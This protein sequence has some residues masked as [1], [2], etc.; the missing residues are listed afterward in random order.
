MRRLIT[1]SVVALLAWAG[2]ARAVEVPEGKAAVVEAVVGQAE[3]LTLK[4]SQPLHVADVLNFGDRVATGE[5]GRIFLRQAGQAVTR[6]A[7]NTELTLDDPGQRKGTFLILAKGFIRFL[8]SH[9]REGESFE[10]RANNAVAAVKGTDAGVEIIG[11]TVQS[12]VYSSDHKDALVVTDGSGQQHDL[13]PGQTGILGPDGFNQHDLNDQDRQHGDDTFHGLPAADLGQ[14]DA[15][16][17]PGHAD[18]D[19]YIQDALTELGHDLKL[20]GNKESQDRNNDLAAGRM[21]VDRFG[22]QVQIANNLY[23]SAPDTVVLSTTTSRLSG[24]VTSAIQTTQWNAALPNDAW[25]K[26]ISLALNDP[27]NLS[28]VP[29]LPSLSSNYPPLWYRLNSHLTIADPV[30]DQ[31]VLTTLYGI[32]YFASTNFVQDYIQD[33]WGYNAVGGSVQLY[34]DLHSA[35]FASATGVLATDA[36]LLS[37][38]GGTVGDSSSYYNSIAPS[39]AGATLYNYFYSTGQALYQSFYVLDAKGG[40][41]AL[42]P[43]VAAGAARTNGGT[44]PNPIDATSFLGMDRSVNLEIEFNLPGFFAQ[45]IDLMAMP[46]LFDGMGGILPIFQA[47]S[48]TG[49]PCNGNCG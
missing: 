26:V 38:F 46:A 25:L 39:G 17:V 47:P 8:V 23:R 29:V 2:A 37:N 44:T 30:G 15:G 6:L 48:S 4:G 42:P 33:L 10:V 34:Y 14:G 5:N 41:L 49:V 11:D 18:L 36:P 19:L 1:V 21:A 13:D 45:P 43:A 3:L 35:W 22:V 12:T 20:D 32:P 16:P 27:A 40:L 28:T 24:G 31:L 7:A 9:R